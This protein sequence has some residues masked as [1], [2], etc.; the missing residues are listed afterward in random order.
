MRKD[1][2]KV[3]NNEN[4]EDINFLKSF[5]TERITLELSLTEEELIA[6]LLVRQVLHSTN[7]YEQLQSNKNKQILPDHLEKVRKEFE[8]TEKKR[9]MIRLPEIRQL[10]PRTQKN[11]SLIPTPTKYEEEKIKDIEEWVSKIDT[12]SIYKSL[13]KQNSLLNYND[14]DIINNFKKPSV[15]SSKTLA[16]IP[17]DDIEIIVDN[18]ST[19]YYATMINFKNSEK[20]KN[21]ANNKTKID[22]KKVNNKYKS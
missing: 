16:M 12:K 15:N 9:N 4:L 17:K 18:K 1:I 2:N 19:N 6:D 20:E 3:K 13:S 10:S 21:N 14:N 22:K 7:E 8:I 11:I 5:T